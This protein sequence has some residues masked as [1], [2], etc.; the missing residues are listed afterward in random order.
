MAS[1]RPTVLVEALIVGFGVIM[2]CFGQIRRCGACRK[3]EPYKPGDNIP[4]QQKILELDKV[5]HEFSLDANSFVWQAS[6][7][8]SHNWVV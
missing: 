8:T 2:R 5:R 6:S 3:Y 1:I 7:Q 4:L